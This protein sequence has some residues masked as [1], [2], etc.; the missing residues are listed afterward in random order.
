MVGFSVFFSSSLVLWVLAAAR[1]G[2]RDVDGQG[3]TP[4]STEWANCLVSRLSVWVIEAFIPV[5]LVVEL[6]YFCVR[7]NASIAHEWSGWLISFAARYASVRDAVR[8]AFRARWYVHT[9]HAV[10]RVSGAARA[11]LA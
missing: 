3:E 1:R 7:M 8:R 2:A 4:W 6:K 11:A 10:R 9:V 5:A